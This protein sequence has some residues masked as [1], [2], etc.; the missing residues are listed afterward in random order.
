MDKIICVGKNY[1]KHAQELGGSVPETPIYFLKPPST[2]FEV[3][4][5]QTQTVPW[6]AQGELH[7]ELELVLRIEKAQSGW[8]FS[9]FSLGL[10]MTLR[11][12]QQ[13]LKKEGQPWEKAKVFLNSSILGPWQPIGDLHE[14]LRMP[15]E[16]HVNKQ[17]RQRGQGQDMRFAPE[18]LLQDLQRWFPLCDGDLLFTGTPE[19]V[20]SIADG[21]QLEINSPNFTFEVRARRI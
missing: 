10:D 3:K 18:F 14:V 12:L 20:A 6:P 17:L 9:H 19:G 2:L 4:A 1:L 7:H 15:F 21:D 11:D 16:L 8:R 13:I 5:G